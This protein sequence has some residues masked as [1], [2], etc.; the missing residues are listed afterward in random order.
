MPHLARMRQEGAYGRLISM[1]PLLSPVVWTVPQP[2]QG[3]TGR[4]PDGAQGLG[5]TPGPEAVNRRGGW[6]CGTV[7]AWHMAC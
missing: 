3:L 2:R 4:V 5:G 6:V 1:K 7:P